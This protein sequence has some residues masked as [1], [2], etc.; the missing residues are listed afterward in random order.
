MSEEITQKDRRVIKEILALEESNNKSKHLT[1][2]DMILKIIDIIKG[3]V[4]DE[5]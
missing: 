1:N 4:K 3:G 5:V 2:Q